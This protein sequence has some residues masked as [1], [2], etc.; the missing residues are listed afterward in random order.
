M[1]EADYRNGIEAM[2][3]KAWASNITPILALPV[4]YRGLSQSIGAMRSWLTA[5]AQEQKIRT[6]DFA[7]VLFDSQG[8]YLPGMSNVGKYLSL[9][10]YRAMGE[11]VAQNNNALPFWGGRGSWD[12]LGIER[13]LDDLFCFIQGADRVD[14]S[15]NSV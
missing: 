11:Y 3:E 2:V 9:Q 13:L 5:Y 8:N 12:R 1:S 15:E 14:A 7:S 10:G 6:L 4:P